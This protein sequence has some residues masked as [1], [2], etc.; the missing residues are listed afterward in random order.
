[1]FRAPAAIWRSHISPVWRAP[2]IHLGLAWA[3][4][5]AL[6]GHDWAVMFDKWWNVSTYNHVLFVPFIAGWL[7]WTRRDLLARLAPAAWWPGLVLVA[8]AL[9]LWLLGTVGGV[10]TASQLGAVMALQGA[11]LAVL[12]PRIGAAL[13]FPLAYLFFLVPFGDELVPALQTITAK[14]V[15]VLTHWSGIPAVIDG[16]FIETPGGLF[17]VAEACSGVKFLIAMAAL[18]TLVA[19][20][21][22][23]SL[24][25]RAAFM[26][27]AIILPIIANSIRAWGTI[28][29]AQSQ[30]IE[31]AAGFDHI[32][33]GWIFFALVVLALLAGAWRWFDRDPDDLAPSIEPIMASPRL[34]WLA[35]HS[36]TSRRALVILGALAAG[37]YAW[38]ATASRIEAQLPVSIELPAVA[39]W[40]R[41]ADTPA[42]AWSPRAT[43][44]GHRLLGRYSANGGA[45]VD[46]FVALYAAQDDGREASAAGEGALVPGT[47]WRWLDTGPVIAGANSDYL[48]ADGHV[49]R[50]A[51]TSYRSGNV[52]TDSAVRLK[53]AA[54]VDRM[55]LR[56]QPTM[57]LILSAEDQGG[58]DAAA[59]IAKFRQAMGDEG[60]WMDRIAGLR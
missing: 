7:V 48:L 17:E 24:R 60:E 2:L 34:G 42:I 53:L 36:I 26:A 20:V 47:Q 45:T 55:M 5:M 9:M 37:F 38:S 3:M 8:G 12:G 14:L 46:V 57:M 25:R 16:V 32:F 21:C 41:S 44:A 19:N 54:M 40:Q 58:A 11:L 18:G 23:K 30:G 29:I 31:F 56:R 43:G 35:S 59:S 27:A 28:Y 13:L 49:K 51:R 6:A 1:M 15:I 10:N 52:L 33:Y 39:G 4:L 50:L 22:F